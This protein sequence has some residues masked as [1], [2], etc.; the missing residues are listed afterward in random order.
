VD[1]DEI[2]GSCPRCDGEFRPGISICPDCGIPLL[3]VDEEAAPL[4][5][6]PAPS[7]DRLTVDPA[8]SGRLTA[9]AAA[10]VGGTALT[11]AGAAISALSFDLGQ[12]PFN[13]L[14]RDERIRYF[15]RAATPGVGIVVLVAGL[16]VAFGGRLRPRNA[17]DTGVQRA[18]FGAAVVLTVL[19][20]VGLVEDW[21][22][23]TDGVSAAQRI[24]TS[25]QWLSTVVLAAAGGLVTDVVARRRP[26]DE[27]ERAK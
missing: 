15:A 10:C 17:L 3:G 12:G 25:S 9:V 7:V 26:V 6:A 2:G 18:T 1:P 14:G 24:W 11:V 8:W 16:A 20:L 23:N 5:P 4:P 21:Q 27:D 22:L 19:A 13:G